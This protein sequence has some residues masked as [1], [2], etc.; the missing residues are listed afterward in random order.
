MPQNQGMFRPVRVVAP[1]GCIFNPNFP[2]ACLARM[3]Q[4][5]RVLD[6]VIRALAPVLPR[7]ASRRSTRR[8]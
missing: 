1:K 3:A 6:C 4:I 7:R 5:Q 2:R 8:T